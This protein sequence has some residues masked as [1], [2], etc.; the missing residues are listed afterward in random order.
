MMHLNNS[1]QYKRSFVNI[2]PQS[3]TDFTQVTCTVHFYYKSESNIT[4]FEGCR[5]TFLRFELSKKVQSNVAPA[6]VYF[7]RFFLLS[8]PYFFI[9]YWIRFQIVLLLI[10]RENSQK[11]FK[12]FIFDVLQ[13]V[14][15][16]RVFVLFSQT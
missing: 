2:N 11:S 6:L 10:Q 12:K 8:A 13:N 1:I 15:L 7:Y 5:T 14:C 3:N 16:K 4:T 9:E